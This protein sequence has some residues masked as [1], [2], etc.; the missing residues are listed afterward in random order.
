MPSPTDLVAVP[1]LRDAMLELALLAV[2]GGVLGAWIVLRRLAFFTHAVGA[3]AFPALVAATAVGLAPQ[4]AGLAAG[5][6]YSAGVRR[7]ARERDPGPA[8]G[9]L[10]VASLGAGVVLAS[11]LVAAGAVVDR[12]LFGSLLGL[13]GADLAFSAVA[14]VAAVVSTAVLGRSWLALGFDPESA[15]ALPATSRRADAL[16]PPLV[17]AAAVAAVPAVGALLV[18]SLFIVPAA[19][20]RMVAT[21]VR[22]LVAG[23]VGVA[24]LQSMAGLY[25]AYALD[26][27]PGPSIA[28]LGAAL[29]GATA[30]A[31]RGRAVGR[32]RT[33]AAAPIAPA[34]GPSR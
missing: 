2:P 11:D 5:L 31:A 3:A 24:L 15:G 8:T 14:A 32:P 4:L 26:T 29:F 13:G 17:A 20:A 25:L 7:I 28:V 34:G 12:L 30:L 23:A 19:T 10:L 22:G 16:L 1:L 27:A 18:T 33:T 9:L 21:T 6:S